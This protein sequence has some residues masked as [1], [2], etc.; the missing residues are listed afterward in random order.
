MMRLIENASTIIHLPSSMPFPL[1]P[2][3][4][5]P[6][7]QHNIRKTDQDAERQKSAREEQW[8][9]LNRLHFCFFDNEQLLTTLLLLPFGPH[10]TGAS[11]SWE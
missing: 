1:L 7:A 11:T 5:R 9:R 3:S 10:V 6:H 4:K 8:C 2:Q